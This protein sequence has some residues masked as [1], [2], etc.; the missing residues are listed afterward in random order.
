ME[1][2]MPN[3]NVVRSLNFGCWTVWKGFTRFGITAPPPL[4]AQESD[5]GRGSHDSWW[6]HRLR[7][8]ALAW[9]DSTL[10]YQKK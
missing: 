9:L 10:L 2:K 7:V 1:R 5:T 3:Y 8:E 6:S 4:D